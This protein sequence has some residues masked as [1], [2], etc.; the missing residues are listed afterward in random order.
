MDW[1]L[2]S[3][4]AVRRDAA[5][6]EVAAGEVLLPVE[7]GALFTVPLVDLRVS[8]PWLT[9]G[10]FSVLLCTEVVVLRPSPFCT[11]AGLPAVL[12]PSPF[13]TAAGLPADLLPAAAELLLS[14]P[15][16]AAGPAP[17]LRLPWVLAYIAS[18]SLLVSGR[19]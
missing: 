16:A 12:R 3:V 19:E 9:A 17:L 6:S 10:R 14:L 4:G 2:C 1:V 8:L 5:W 15:E 11:A 7:T 13:C 18:P